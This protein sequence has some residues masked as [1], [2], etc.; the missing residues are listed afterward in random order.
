MGSHWVGSPASKERAACRLPGD[1]SLYSAGSTLIFELF[2]ALPSPPLRKSACNPCSGKDCPQVPLVSLP[3]RAPDFSPADAP[4][5]ESSLA[6]RCRTAR[7]RI[8]GTPLAEDASKHAPRFPRWYRCSRRSLAQRE[9][10]NYSP[11]C[12]PTERSTNRIL[13]RRILLSRQSISSRSAARPTIF[14]WD[15]R[16]VSSP[17]R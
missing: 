16:E 9:R 8:P 2:A 13:L 12:R 11:A 10:D 4:Q 14:P 3:A 1:T 5:Q 17:R 7:H 6:C 15:G